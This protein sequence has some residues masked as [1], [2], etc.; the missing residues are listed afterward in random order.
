MIW[1]SSIFHDIAHYLHCTIY[2]H[3]QRARSAHRPKFRQRKRRPEPCNKTLAFRLDHVMPFSLYS[4]QFS[5]LIAIFQLLRLSIHSSAGDQDD[6][7]AD[8]KDRTDNVEDCST[9]TG[10]GTRYHE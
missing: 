4:K 10:L 5:L 8:D 1:V 2:Y 6:T 3:L 7:S 9:D